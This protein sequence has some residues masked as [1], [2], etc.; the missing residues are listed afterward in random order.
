MKRLATWEPALVAYL[1]ACEAR[2]FAWGRHD[3]ALFAAGAVL[4]MTG[5]DPAARYRGRY[6]SA[7]G[8]LRALRRFGAGS[9]EAELDTLFARK[10]PAL[11]MRGDLALVDGSVG[12][13]VGGHALFVGEEGAAEGLVRHPRAAWSAAWGV[14]FHG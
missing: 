13:V 3:C 14:P 8:S 12:V 5:E 7:A 11:A 4:A 2:P 9:L 6:R 1:E 10:A